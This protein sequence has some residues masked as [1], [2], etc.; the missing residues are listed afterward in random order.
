[1]SG[2]VLDY[3]VLSILD[4]LKSRPRSRIR[5]QRHCGLGHMSLSGS[6]TGL[7]SSPT[8]CKH[9]Q[10]QGRGQ[11]RCNLSQDLIT[12]LTECISHRGLPQRERLGQGFSPVSDLTIDM[13]Q[14]ESMKTLSARLISWD[15][16]AYLRSHFT[17]CH[18]WGCK[19]GVWSLL[20]DLNIRL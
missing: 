6:S 8:L 14:G 19:K 17:P 16:S 13:S 15:I 2:L 11:T 4:K 3:V 5:P 1:M 12:V 10:G 18:L 20:V 7:L 9:L